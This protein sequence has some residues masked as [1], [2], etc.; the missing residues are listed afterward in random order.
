MVAWLIT[1]ACAAS[2]SAI[3]FSTVYKKLSE[4]RRNLESLRKQLLV[5]ENAS[6]QIRDGPDSELATRMQET[7]QKI[8]RTA[9]ADYNRLMK[10]PLNCM[11]TFLMGFHTEG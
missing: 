8:Y 11:P 3:W 5:H 1:G 4:K 2:M 10:R 7:N 6:V 9:A